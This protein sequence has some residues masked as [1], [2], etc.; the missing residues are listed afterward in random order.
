MIEGSSKSLF[1]LAVKKYWFY[2]QHTFERLNVLHV[3]FLLY[4]ITLA[5]YFGCYFT[6]MT[7]MNLLKAK[8]LYSTGAITLSAYWATCF[9]VII[10]N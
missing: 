8:A 4:V 5:L 9:M 7:C 2:Y 10:S 3:G 1:A 6:P